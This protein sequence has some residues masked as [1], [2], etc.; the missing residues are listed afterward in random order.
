MEDPRNGRC[1]WRHD[2][3]CHLPN[4]HW[5]GDE[6]LSP[7]SPSPHS[8]LSS[9]CTTQ[10]GWRMR[11]WLQGS[12]SS[13]YTHSQLS[14][15]YSWTQI[16]VFGGQLWRRSTSWIPAV[17]SGFWLHLK[18][19]PRWSKC[20]TYLSPGGQTPLH[21]REPLLILFVRKSIILK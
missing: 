8:Q 2:C 10:G 9:G 19:S 14:R 11:T 6:V 12:S 4:S 17:S 13:S 18:E 21:H 1:V 20:K 3:T 5:G 16:L 7:V 15:S